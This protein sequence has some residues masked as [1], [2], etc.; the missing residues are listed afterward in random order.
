MIITFLF[1]YRANHHFHTCK[2]L[3]QTPQNKQPTYVLAVELEN[4]KAA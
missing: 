3:E 1:Q 4:Q 2:M